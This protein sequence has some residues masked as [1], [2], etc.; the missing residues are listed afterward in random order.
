M[1]RLRLRMLF[2]IVLCAEMPLVGCNVGPIAPPGIN[3][4]PPADAGADQNADVGQRVCLNGLSSTD[5]DDDPLTCVCPQ[6]S[7][8]SVSPLIPQIRLIAMGGVS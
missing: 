3:Q 6:H 2:T 4:A 7:E 8:P 1:F 5:P